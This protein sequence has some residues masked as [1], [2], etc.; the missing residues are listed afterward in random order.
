MRARTCGGF[1]AGLFSYSRKARSV[2]RR[3]IR[4]FSVGCLGRER[5][6]RAVNFAIVG[7]IPGDENH[8]GGVIFIVIQPEEFF[9]ERGRVAGFVLFAGEFARRLRS[10]RRRES[11][12]F[13]TMRMT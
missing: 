5:E 8:A 7:D 6:F 11:R 1:C 9:S 4:A 2:S 12:T 10:A 3:P 13:R